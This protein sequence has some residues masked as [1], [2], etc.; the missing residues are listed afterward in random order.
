MII[1]LWDRLARRA[2]KLKLGLASVQIK[3]LGTH[4][5]EMF[6]T[7]HRPVGS[8]VAGVRQQ[9]NNRWLIFL[10]AL[11]YKLAQILLLLLLPIALKGLY[12]C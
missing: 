4:A 10:L 1:K 3:L 12:T 6:I 9:S 5:S 2:A 11:K 8:A 7:A